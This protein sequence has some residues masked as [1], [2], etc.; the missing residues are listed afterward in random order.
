MP[1]SQTQQTWRSWLQDMIVDSQERRRIANE[2]GINPATL[3]RWAHNESSPRAQN[4]RQL[5]K[6]FPKHRE[7]LLQLI[8]E[9]YP[10][11]DEN[12]QQLRGSEEIRVDVIPSEFYARAMRTQAITPRI[13]RYQTLGD[14]ILEQA[15]KHLDP[16]HVGVG[17]S[18]A[19]CLPPTRGESVRSL[20][21]DLGRGSPPWMP[22][23]DNE[24]MLLGAESLAGYTAIYARTVALS[25]LFL[26][27]TTLPVS[28]GMWE[29]SAVAAPIM[30]EGKVAGSLLASSVLT[31]YFTAERVMIVSGYADLVALAF[32]GAH[33]YD[34]QFIQLR[35]FPT[36][37][38]QQPAIRSFRERVSE[39]MRKQYSIGI[40]HAEQLAWQQI[41]EELLHLQLTKETKEE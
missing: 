24:S 4:L 19:R 16:D 2:L 7:I 15:L 8:L 10:I 3:T 5:L 12:D 23:M 25:D 21:V 28:V 11:L 33:F 36:Q 13:I 26:T 38:E 20:L 35:V 6:A 32:E 40:V 18:I 27:T 41:E 29:R 1:D 22:A 39:I 9:E 34:P 17:I 14:L 37:Q 31:D 30:F